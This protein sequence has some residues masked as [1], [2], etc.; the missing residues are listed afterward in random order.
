MASLPEWM[1][2]MERT[3]REFANGLKQ[4]TYTVSIAIEHFHSF[5]MA[6]A[7]DVAVESFGI[8][9]SDIKKIESKDGVVYAH[10]YNH[11]KILL[12]D[13]NELE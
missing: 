9:R 2:I 11:R 8:A 3:T 10:L 4:I 6:L 12:W 13:S 5:L 1:E 7:E